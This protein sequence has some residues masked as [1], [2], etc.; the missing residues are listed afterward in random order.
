MRMRERAKERGKW[1]LGFDRD[2]E[3]AGRD[4]IRMGE[5]LDVCHGGIRRAGWLGWLPHPPLP[6]VAG[7]RD[8]WGVG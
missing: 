2:G 5:A 1:A 7:G 6:P 8:E 4:L 3:E